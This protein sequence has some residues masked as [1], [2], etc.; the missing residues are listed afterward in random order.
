MIPRN[1]L[2]TA[3]PWSSSTAREHAI[4]YHE[5]S[6]VQSFVEITRYLNRTMAPRRVNRRAV[7][8]ATSK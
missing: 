5:T 1:K 7:S 4:P 8:A 2:K 6:M 3:R